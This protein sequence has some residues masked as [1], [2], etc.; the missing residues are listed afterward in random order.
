M[1]KKDSIKINLEKPIYKNNYI[2]RTNSIEDEIPNDNLLN[3]FELNDNL[4]NDLELNDNLEK[5]CFSPS[6]K[7]DVFII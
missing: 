3:D 2:G 5:R 1:K 4:L 7:L 6:N